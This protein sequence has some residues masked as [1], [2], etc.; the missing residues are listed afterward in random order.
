[1]EGTEQLRAP[2]AMQRVEGRVGVEQQLVRTTDF[3]IDETFHG[4]PGARRYEWEPTFFLRRI[5][6]L[7]LE[8]RAMEAHPR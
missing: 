3:R 5:K 6:E 2:R 7:Y 4:P 1:M 8:F